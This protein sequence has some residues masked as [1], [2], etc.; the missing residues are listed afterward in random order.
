METTS[1]ATRWTFEDSAGTHWIELNAGAETITSY[2]GQPHVMSITGVY[3]ASESLYALA[4]DYRLTE[5]GTGEPVAL[6]TADDIEAETGT[7]PFCEAV[8]VVGGTAYTVAL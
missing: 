2:N 4:E 3:R 1:I 7:T 8:L 6:L 5:T